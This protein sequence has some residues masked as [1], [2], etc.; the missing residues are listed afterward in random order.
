MRVRVVGAVL[1]V[2]LGCTPAVASD[3]I[4]GQAFIIDGDTIRLGDTRIRLHGIDA[5]EAAQS[6][7]AAGGGTWAC[8]TAATRALRSIVADREVVCQPLT[9]DRYGRTIA[10]CFV[11]A[12]D[13]EAEMVRQGYAWAFVKYSTDYVGEEAEARAAHGGIWQAET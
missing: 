10:R 11:G 6:C 7:N 2:W 1:L 5:P 9:L 13:I 12:A 4:A 3:L 8:G